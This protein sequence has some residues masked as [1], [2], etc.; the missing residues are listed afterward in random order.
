[1]TLVGNEGEVV[2]MGMAVGGIAKVEDGGGYENATSSGIV[3]TWIVITILSVIE[4]IVV[5]RTPAVKDGRSSIG[6]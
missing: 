3:L 1:M 5:V 4:G 2:M 6:K